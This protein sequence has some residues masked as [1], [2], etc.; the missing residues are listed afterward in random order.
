M[1]IGEFNCKMDSKGRI[2]FPAKF[3]EQ[4]TD[5]FVITRGLDNCINLFTLEK[6]NEQTKQIENMKYTNKNHR[7]YSRFILSAAT[8]LNFDTQG[9]INIPQSLIEY[10]KLEKEII[11]TGNID[12]IEIWSKDVWNKYLE[13]NL[14]NIEELADDI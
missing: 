1:F 13:E 6:W 2:T 12:R 9:R 11:V 5:N 4:L 3:R 14:E 10:S 8:E 7:A